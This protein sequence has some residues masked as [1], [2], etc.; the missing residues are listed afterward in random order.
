MSRFSSATILP[1]E[2]ATLSPHFSPGEFVHPELMGREFI[3]WL[4][5][6]RAAA[7]VPMHI[8]SSARTLEH[9]AQ[10]GG[11][12]DSAHTDPICNAVDIG[13][14]PTDDDPNWNLARWQIV[15]AA[16]DHGC[17]RIGIYPNGS[18]HLDRTEDVRPSPRLW[19][20]VD[21]PASPV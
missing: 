16:I 6:V 2:W 13:K 12:K 1:E 15:K 21:N 20:A 4:N 14:A 11:A 3:V 7:G 10:V 8:T 5:Q 19:I 18:L 9:N 17:T